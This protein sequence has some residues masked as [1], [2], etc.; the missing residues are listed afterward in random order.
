M[1][2][3]RKKHGLTT[4]ELI[5]VIAITIILAGSAAPIYGG[6]QVQSQLNEASSGVVQALRAAREESTS[7]VNNSA[8]GVRFNTTNYSIYEGDSYTTRVQSE[9]RT[10]TLRSAVSLT[11]TLTND[12]VNFSKGRGIP[13]NTGSVT[14]THVTSGTRVIMINEFGVIDEN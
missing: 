4:I 8:H 7:G 10:F 5:I 2:W 14:L 9:D 13:D 6:L 12:E 1:K 3:I 11:T